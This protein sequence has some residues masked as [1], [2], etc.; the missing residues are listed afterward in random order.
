MKKIETDSYILVP[1]IRNRYKI[2]MKEA[3]FR[4]KDAKQI[5]GCY[6]SGNQK[7]WVFPQNRLADFNQWFEQIETKQKLQ[8]EHANALKSYHEQLILR[9][10]S[11]NTI[12]VYTDQFKK[13]LRFYD[14]KNPTDISD[15]DVKDY[16]LNLLSTKDI[17]S[18]Y[19]KQ[20]ACSIKFYFEK[21]LQR[22]TKSYFFDI[23]IKKAK[24]LPVV[25][26][27]KE[28]KLFFQ[29]ITDE[30]KLAIFK[31]IYSA[32]LRLSELVNLKISDI[33]SENMWIRVQG[34]KGMKD[35]ITILSKELL[36][37]LRHYAKR[38]KPEYWLF[39][40]SPRTPYHKRS[41]QKMFHHYYALTRLTKKA[42]VHTLRHSFAT[43]LL[44]NGE[45]VRKIQKLL[46]HK[47]L[48]TTEIYTHITS[49]AMGGIRSPL[50][51]L[52]IGDKEDE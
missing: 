23:P 34:G 36:W 4:K 11:E 29:K 24:K 47:N 5:R 30:K 25:L 21:I 39:E 38:Y 7:S 9:R 46:G 42:S 31:T 44:E 16:L 3:D 52:E 12:L 49:Q 27:N 50:D 35:R 18:S 13:F 19:Q 51:Y 45:D 2:I 48:A 41:I 14:D 1:I 43:H 22:E 26:S 6:F 32:G 8:R 17:S 33:D 20:V 28:V 37:A 40:S 10:Y 15:E